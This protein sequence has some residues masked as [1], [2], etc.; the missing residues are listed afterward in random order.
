MKL[1]AARSHLE[2]VIAGYAGDWT[3]IPYRINWD[4]VQEAIN[5]LEEAIRNDQD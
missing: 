3:T 2:E 5:N 1:M 4:D